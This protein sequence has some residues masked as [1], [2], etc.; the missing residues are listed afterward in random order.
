MFGERKMGHVFLTA[1]NAVF[2]IV[3]LILVGAYLRKIGLLSEG[4][5][6][7]GNKLVFVLCLPVA[8]FINVYNIE[9]IYDLRWDVIVYCVVMVLVIFFLG[10]ATAVMTTK[11]HTRRGVLLQC[12]FRSN[13]AIIGLPL[14]AA[15]GGSEAQAVAALVS[16]FVIPLFN[17]LAVIALSMFDN[18]QQRHH[19][20]AVLV[21]IMKNPLIIGTCLA[22]VCLVIRHLQVKNLGYLAFSIKGQLP[23]VYT[24]LNY[25]KNCVTPLALIVMG[26]QFQFSA[27]RGIL[28]EITVGT[29]WRIV[30]APIL[31]VGIAILLSRYTGIINFGINEYPALVALFGSPV[32]VSSAIMAKQMGGD[33]QLATQ[34]VVWSSIA[35]VLTVF[36][37]VSGLMAM[38]L[39]T[40][41]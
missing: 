26:G 13:Y 36:L 4:F 22:I 21:D 37:L 28:K 23:F 38:G 11:E 24:A 29:L 10:L 7:T 31:G 15:I 1:A 18:R 12:V 35:S 33:E 6:K 14:A 40:G 3:L 32:A 34:Y 20:R 8:L 17:V 19:V 16:A 25:L 41:I 5:L 9:N 30:L 39:L 27:T 2:P